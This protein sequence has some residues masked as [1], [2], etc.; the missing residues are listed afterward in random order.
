MRVCGR[1]SECGHVKAPV[2]TPLLARIMALQLL[3]GIQDLL[4]NPNNY[5]P[6]SEAAGRARLTGKPPSAVHGSPGLRVVLTCAHAACRRSGK[7]TSS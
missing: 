5:D 6:V 7:R 3:T 4:D 1:A 2:T